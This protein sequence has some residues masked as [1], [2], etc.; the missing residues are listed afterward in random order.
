VCGRS[1]LP[2]NTFTVIADTVPGSGGAPN[3]GSGN[4]ILSWDRS[5]DHLSGEYDVRQYVLYRRDDTATVWT[6]P[7]LTVKA[8]TTL[9]YHILV[10]GQVSGRTYTFAVAAQDCTPAESSLLIQNQIAP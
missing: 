4:V 10:G 6:D 9:V 1:P 7:L 8:D 3:V 2:P 5:P